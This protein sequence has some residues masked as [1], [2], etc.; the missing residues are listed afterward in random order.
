MLNYD[1]VDN[2]I[3]IDERC[4][5]G[6]RV[7]GLSNIPNDKEFAIIISCVSGIAALGPN[8]IAV[9]IHTGTVLLFE[10]G[11]DGE[12]VIGRLV[13]S[14]RSHDFPITDLASTSMSTPSSENR[15]LLASGDLVGYISQ[16]ARSLSAC[17]VY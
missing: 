12:N 5:E 16:N 8:F 1:F 3:G 2:G 17:I 13:D 9:G 4:V 14:R 11:I 7:K 10:I 15:A 6:G